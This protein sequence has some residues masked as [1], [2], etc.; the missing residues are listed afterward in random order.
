MKEGDLFIVS[1]DT[2]QG[3]QEVLPYAHQVIQNAKE[4]GLLMSPSGMATKEGP[5]TPENVVRIL[6]EYV[7]DFNHPELTSALAGAI[8]HLLF[9]TAVDPN[10]RFAQGVITELGEY[11]ERENIRAELEGKTKKQ[12][13]IRILGQL[14]AGKTTFM[15]TVSRNL[16]LARV[17]LGIMAAEP[18]DSEAYYPELKVI[19]RGEYVRSS[20]RGAKATLGFEK[21]ELFGV[22]P[23]GKEI[24]GITLHSGGGHMRADGPR[25]NSKLDSAGFFV[26]FLSLEELSQLTLSTPLDFTL[27]SGESVV[28]TLL[29]L[30]VRLEEWRKL[31]VPKIGVI[32]KFPNGQQPTGETSAYI[33]RAYRNAFNYAQTHRRDLD[34]IAQ[35]SGKRV[36]IPA[37]VNLGQSVNLWLP[38]YDDAPIY[39]GSLEVLARL[40]DIAGGIKPITFAEDQDEK[41]VYY[42]KALAEGK[43][44]G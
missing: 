18:E 3:R 26:D 35:L 32:T 36:V 9:R 30:T 40:A 23:D 34:E 21:L 15:E 29:S 17:N 22:T 39:S 42:K 13:D 10:D 12:I 8:N 38:I 11:E 5:I 7:I 1:L 37:S 44:K 14:A 4:W 25:P 31:T 43:G 6:S 28:E 33:N 2:P 19:N 16:A 24:T 20:S 41:F 27:G